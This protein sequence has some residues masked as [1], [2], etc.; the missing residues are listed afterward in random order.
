MEGE[1]VEVL[2]YRPDYLA[3]AITRGGGYGQFATEDLWLDIYCHIATGS[4]TPVPYTVV[5]AAE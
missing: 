2:G 1:V 3:A 4:P 5:I